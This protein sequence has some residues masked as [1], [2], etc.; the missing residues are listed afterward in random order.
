[1]N[2]KKAKQIRRWLGCK[3]RFPRRPHELLPQQRSVLREAYKA[4]SRL[5]TPQR[6]VLGR[7]M[8]R[9]LRDERI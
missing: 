7:M 1:M 2:G 8:R 6:V 4:Y 3:I 9:I 5:N